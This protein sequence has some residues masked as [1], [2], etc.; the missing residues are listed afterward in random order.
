VEVLRC[1]VKRGCAFGREKDSTCR[2]NEKKEKQEE[3]NKPQQPAPISFKILTYIP[4]LHEA[5]VYTTNTF[6][7]ISNGKMHSRAQFPYSGAGLGNDSV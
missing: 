3:V 7:N 1:I 5:R 6:P 2:T 4:T